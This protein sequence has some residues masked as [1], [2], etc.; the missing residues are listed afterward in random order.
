MNGN[1]VTWWLMGILA[2]LL[3]GGASAWLTSMH[4]LTRIHGE[5]IAVLESQI[6]AQRHQLDRIDRKLDRLLEREKGPR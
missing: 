6:E 4:T 1:K 5:K 3:T 2:T